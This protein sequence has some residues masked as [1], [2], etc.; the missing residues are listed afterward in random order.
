[1]RCRRLCK[2]F[3]RTE[4]GFN[5]IQNAPQLLMRGAVFKTDLPRNTPMRHGA[6]ILYRI[7]GQ[8][9]VRQMNGNTIKAAHQRGE[10]AELHHRTYNTAV[11]KNPAAIAET[12]FEKNRDATDEILEEILRAEC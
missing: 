10:E 7:D 2:A 3:R 8:M 1:M 12:L 4:V 11:H 6:E 5:I 9:L